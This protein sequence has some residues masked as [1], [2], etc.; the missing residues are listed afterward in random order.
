MELTN[1]VMVVHEID[2]ACYEIDG[3]ISFEQ[4]QRY[5]ETVTGTRVKRRTEGEGESNRRLDLTG[6]YHDRSH[7]GHS[8]DL[9]TPE[10]RPKQA[11][12]GGRVR[13]HFHSNLTFLT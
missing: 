10:N 1:V 6:G 13:I 11:T 12:S 5:F 8:D 7:G 3:E 4:V 9:R 2:A